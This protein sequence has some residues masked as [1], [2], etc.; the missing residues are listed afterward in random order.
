VYLARSPTTAVAE[1]FGTEEPTPL[2][3]IPV[4]YGLK[5]VIDL[6]GDLTGWPADWRNWNCNWRAALSDPTPDC[7]SWRCGDDAIS[8][9]ASAILYPSQHDPS[10]TALAV[11]TEDA[12]LGTCN[13]E[14]QDPFG[15][16][17][18]AN[19]VRV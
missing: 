12:V 11:F 5:R 15:A 14:V 18:E 17:S 6:T 2:V 8:R 1:Y 3:L 7:A 19:P 4:R 9:S 16:I 13:V 10:G